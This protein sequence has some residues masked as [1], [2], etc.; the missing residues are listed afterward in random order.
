MVPNTLRFLFLQVC[1]FLDAATNACSIYPVRPLQCSTYP[2][3]PEI[4][5]ASNWAVEQQHWCEGIE[6]PD[7]PPLDRWHAAQQLQLAT[8]HTLALEA[9]KPAG[10]DADE[11]LYG[12]RS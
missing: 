12:G 6:H 2:W 9:A 5:A 7:A 3:W 1:V 10:W 11:Q 4:M 8:E